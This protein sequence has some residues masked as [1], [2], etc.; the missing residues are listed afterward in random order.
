MKNQ[1]I[2]KKEGK[3]S[4]DRAFKVLYGSKSLPS[5]SDNKDPIYLSYDPLV[6]AGQEVTVMKYSGEKVCKAVIVNCNKITTGSMPKQ[7]KENYLRSGGR[8]DCAWM[9]SFKKV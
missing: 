8:K 9:V 2:L 4:P 6:V 1:I 5:P 7:Q 3:L